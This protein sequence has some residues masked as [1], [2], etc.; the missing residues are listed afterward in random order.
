MYL[1]Y[2]LKDRLLSGSLFV[3]NDI[4][5]NSKLIHPSQW[6]TWPTVGTAKRGTHLPTPFPYIRFDLFYFF[7]TIFKFV[8]LSIINI[9]ITTVYAILFLRLC[10]VYT[11][12]NNIIYLKPIKFLLIFSKC[13]GFLS[14]YIIYDFP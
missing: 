4:S 9:H 13:L 1:W 12:Y 8:I 10:S 5:F 14:T 7:F 11:S 3:Y 2:R 6:P